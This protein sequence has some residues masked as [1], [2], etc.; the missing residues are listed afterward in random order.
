MNSWVVIAGLMSWV[1]VFW[2]VSYFVALMSHSFGRPIPLA[3]RAHQELWLPAAP[4]FL[5]EA[6]LIWHSS[7]PWMIICAVVN[8]LA[9]WGAKDWPDENKWTK[10][11]RKLKNKIGV[12]V[13]GS[14]LVVGQART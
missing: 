3:V 2:F 4:G 10:R 14:R 9:W 1:D 13:R 11:G 12:L 6:V 7:A 8:V 5:V